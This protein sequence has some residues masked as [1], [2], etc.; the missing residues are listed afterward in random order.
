MVA[1]R[2]HGLPCGEEAGARNFAFFR[3]KWLQA[4]MQGTSGMRRVRLG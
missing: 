3:V 1:S 2:L 4:T